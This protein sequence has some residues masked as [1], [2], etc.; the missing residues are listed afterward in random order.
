MSEWISCEERLPDHE[1]PFL[2]VHYPKVLRER[3]DTDY[4]TERDQFVAY[5]CEEKWSA[6]LMFT[7]ES[8]PIKDVTFWRELDWPL[9][10]PPANGSERDR[11]KEALIAIHRETGFNGGQN[12][13]HPLH[14][15]Y[16]ISDAALGDPAKEF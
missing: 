4:E 14:K 5:Y 11:L 2:V 16:C 8:F 10:A 7:S 6:C 12:V 9:P 3:L 13:G 15:V 1:G